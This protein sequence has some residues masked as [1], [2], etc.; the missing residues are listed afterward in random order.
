MSKGRGTLFFYNPF[1][2]A[3]IQLPDLKRRYNLVSIAFSSLPTSSDYVVFGIAHDDWFEISI[4]VVAW[5]N[6]FWRS[7]R[8]LNTNVEK[9]MPCINNPVFYNGAF[10][11]LDYNGTLGVFNLKNGF[12]WKVL[13]KPREH[14]NAVYPSFLVECDG[15]LLLVD[16]GPFGKSVGI[17]RLDF[18][19]MVWVKVESLGTHMLF[20]SN[21]SCLSAIA[22]N[23][24]M[25]NKIYFARLH[26]EG[27]LFYSLDTGSYHCLGS[28][29]SVKDFYDTTEQLNCTW[30]EPNWLGTTE[31]ELDWLSI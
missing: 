31:Q 13:V 22:P 29:H 11:C 21:T 24:C 8:F 4:F 7:R 19:K 10:Y 28:Q 2:R 30:I 23:S 17:F 1:T 15:K 18:S 3:T 6:N 25:E 14:F 5:G 20:I 12:I 9:Y 27:I 16:L 26:G